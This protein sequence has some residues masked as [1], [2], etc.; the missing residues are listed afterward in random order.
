VYKRLFICCIVFFVAFP[1]WAQWG[2]KKSFEFL[3]VPA[4]ARLAALGGVNV[5][6]ADSDIN[7]L[8]SNP[9][10]VSDSL[11]GS[12]AAGYTFYI[13]DVGQS[14]FAYAHDF[15]K[16]GTLSFGVQH[17]GYGELMGYDETGLELGTF[18]SGETALVVGKSH[19]VSNFRIGVNLK[20]VFS[21]IA[22]Y[23][24]SAVMFDLGGV[25]IHPRQDLK[26]GLVLRN[27]GFVFSEY[28]ET[29]Q[30]KVPFDVQAGISFKPEHMPVRISLTAYN[31]S[32]N[33]A[34]DNPDDATDD[35]SSFGKIMQH[36]NVGAELLIHRNVNV[37]LGYNILRQAELKTD[38]GG[39]GFT[40]GASV[41]IKA[42]DFVFS[43][44]AYSA[45]NAS[46]AFTLIG[47]LNKMIFKKRTI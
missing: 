46:Y 26:V 36:V 27:L 8:F 5:S 21:N 6:L 25:F 31:L 33:A 11:A 40:A 3:N 15:K 12:A 16:I 29:S 18:Q 30:T 22:G 19:Q 10:L 39:N 34:Y 41:K 7:F 47:D 14:A 45:G 38:N 44:S 43:R 20:S 23:R 9:A 37:L 32:S 1:A 13:A 35:V 2:G 24:A 4:H 28:S 42:F 17:M